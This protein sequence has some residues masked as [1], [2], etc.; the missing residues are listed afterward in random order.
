MGRRVKVYSFARKRYNE[1]IVEMKNF[2]FS[3]FS[4]LVVFLIF[5]PPYPQKT[6]LLILFILFYCCCPLSKFGEVHGT[7]IRV[8]FS[9]ILIWLWL[10][11]FGWYRQLSL[12]WLGFNQRWNVLW[13]QSFV[14]K[15]LKVS[16]DSWIA[17]SLASTIVR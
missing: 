14:I 7:F 4:Q 10:L 12:A 1:G 8:R 6:K 13:C 2:V 16:H 9:E 5:T 15:W 3:I 17:S 11:A